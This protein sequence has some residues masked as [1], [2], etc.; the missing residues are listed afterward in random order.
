[1]VMPKPLPAGGFAVPLKASFLVLQPL[2]IIAVAHNNAAPRLTLFEDTVEFRVLSL[3]RRSYAEIEAVDAQQFI[4]TQNIILYWRKRL[5]GFSGNIGAEDQLI[6]LLAFF[7]EKQLSLTDR[8][9]G[10][11]VRAAKERV[12]S[13]GN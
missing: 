5:L 7:E 3:Q 13:K 4:G 2:P 6:V 10:I 9:R 11:L 1:M 8:A 12:K